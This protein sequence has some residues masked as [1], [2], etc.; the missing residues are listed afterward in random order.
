MDMRNDHYRIQDRHQQG[1]HLNAVAVYDEV[2]GLYHAGIRLFGTWASALRHAGLNSAE[3]QR[4][5]FVK[6]PN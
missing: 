6:Y 5:R 1:Q 2:E 3:I 4:S